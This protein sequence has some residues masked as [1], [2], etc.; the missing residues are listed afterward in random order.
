MKE[1]PE[2]PRIEAIEKRPRLLRS[3][4]LSF[5]A[6]EGTGSSPPALL[7]YTSLLDI[8]RPLHLDISQ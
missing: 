5:P 2:Q 8:L 7:T 6:F 4:H 1:V 3:A